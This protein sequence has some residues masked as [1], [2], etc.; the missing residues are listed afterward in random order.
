MV[1][2][3]RNDCCAIQN[4]NSSF[5]KNRAGLSPG[6][7]V[8]VCATRRDR[9]CNT[10]YNTNR[11]TEEKKQAWLWFGCPDRGCALGYEGV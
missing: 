11:T 1:P 4:S 9:I 6:V 7:V 3:L 5:R 10:S 2:Y 8:L